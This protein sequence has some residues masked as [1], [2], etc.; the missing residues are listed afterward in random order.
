MFS[1]SVDADNPGQVTIDLRASSMGFDQAVKVHI[2]LA[3]WSV[4]EKIEKAH[5][6][7]F[8]CH[9]DHNGEWS[10]SK[11]LQSTD[12]EFASSLV[13][14]SDQDD[15]FWETVKISDPGVYYF[16]FTYC[17][18]EGEHWE[19]EPTKIRGNIKDVPHI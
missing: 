10:L 12:M 14:Q 15:K 7:N 13:I 8:I 2:F 6:S 11:A 4:L 9:V 1:G 19:D 17:P 5:Q 3:H 18:H 16:L